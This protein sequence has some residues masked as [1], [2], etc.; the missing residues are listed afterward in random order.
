MLQLAMLPS[1]LSMLQ[2][3]Q[4]ENTF[5]KSTFFFF[6]SKKGT[7]KHGQYKNVNTRMLLATSL[8]P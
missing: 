3:F 8:A 7:E 2:L 6:F 5:R 1:Q 4:A